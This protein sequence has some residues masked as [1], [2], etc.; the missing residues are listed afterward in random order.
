MAAY[1]RPIELTYIHLK[2]QWELSSKLQIK[3]RPLP[4]FIMIFLNQ[5]NFSYLTWYHIMLEKFTLLRFNRKMYN[6][7][8]YTHLGFNEKAHGFF[9]MTVECKTSYILK[10]KIVK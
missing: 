7:G 6:N 8:I 4:L 10:F 9:A 1:A 3:Q 5:L 2:K